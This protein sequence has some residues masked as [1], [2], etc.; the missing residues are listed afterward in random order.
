MGGAKPSSKSLSDLTSQEMEIIKVCGG[1]AL[2]QL[3]RSERK[4][5]YTPSGPRETRAH[6]QRPHNSDFYDALD[7]QDANEN[8][9]DNG[10]SHLVHNGTSWSRRRR[11]MTSIPPIEPFDGQNFARSVV[12]LAGMA[13]G[14][15]ILK[16]FLRK[17]DDLPIRTHNKDEI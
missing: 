10:I 2:V 14:V 3:Q 15:W 16:R 9:K 17:R 11:A 6:Y 13:V 7:R 12:A 5:P 4:Y 1:A 8:D